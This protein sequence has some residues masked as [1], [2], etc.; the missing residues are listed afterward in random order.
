MEVMDALVSKGGII[1]ALEILK[2]G[3]NGNGKWVSPKNHGFSGSSC[4]LVWCGSVFLIRGTK[5]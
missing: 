1:S 5:V 3:K 4:Y 2:K